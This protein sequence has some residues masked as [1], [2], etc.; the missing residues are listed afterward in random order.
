MFCS[1]IDSNPRLARCDLAGENCVT[2]ASGVMVTT[3]LA[4]DRRNDNVYYTDTLLD[5]IYVVTVDGERHRIVVRYYSDS[6]SS[7]V[8]QRFTECCSLMNFTLPLTF[9]W[10]VTSVYVSGAQIEH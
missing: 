1:A 9:I 7:I 2:I 5:Y 3:G 10:K 8:V 6:R 4:V